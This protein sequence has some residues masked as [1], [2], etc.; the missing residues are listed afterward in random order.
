LCNSILVAGSGSPRA[1]PPF[2]ARAE[3]FL[4]RKDPEMMKTPLPMRAGL[5]TSAALAVVI[6]LAT[7]MP[8]AAEDTAA[9]ANDLLNATLWM[10]R[11]VEYKAVTTSLYALAK[12]RLDEA[13]AD[14]SWTAVPDKQGENF[15][16][17]P[18]AIV[19]D[20]DETVL[21]NNP[22][23]ASLVTRGTDFKSKE[24]TQY[25]ND[26]VTKAVPGA[27]E[28]T[29]YAD[30]KGVKVFFVSNRTK[31]EEPATVENMTALGFPGGGNVDT[32][33]SAG[34]Q[35]EWKSAKENRVA[36]V[37]KDYRVMLLIGDNLGDF[38]DKYKGTLDERQKFFED[39]ATH[40]GHDWIAI[41]NAEYGSFESAPFGHDFKQ[42]A[43][44]RRKKKIEA[45]QPWTPKS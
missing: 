8:A 32:F 21:D 11:S 3:C 37:A 18:P 28:F 10:Q 5:A 31:E 9:P 36:F 16:D 19:L 44:E 13:L 40:W 6:A 34:E 17:K 15:G 14:K 43:D 33:L 26:K 24:W 20:A 39:N 27:V 4:D 1:R 38:T 29:K 45:L 42:P 35:P 41:P 12:I 2:G 7:D 22:Y 23:E 30:S 25:V